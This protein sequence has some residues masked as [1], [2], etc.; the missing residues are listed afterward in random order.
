M[1]PYK[2]ITGDTEDEVWKQITADLDTEED[3]FEYYALIEQ[4]NREIK[5]AID[6]DLGGGFEGGYETTSFTALLPNYHGFKFAIH[7]DSFIDDIGKF[8]GLQDVEVGYPELDRHLIIKTN[9]ED[10][11]KTV[12]ADSKV[13]AIF[14]KLQDFDFGIRHHHDDDSDSEQNFLELNI[15]DGITNPIVLRKLYNAFFTV[16]VTIDGY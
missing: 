5:L 16:L 14:E 10:K 3:L 11:V 8:F 6:I 13:R 15:D 2:T 1:E 9:D 7:E 12:F 4:G